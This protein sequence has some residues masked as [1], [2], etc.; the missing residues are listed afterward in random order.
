MQVGQKLKTLLADVELEVQRIVRPG[1]TDQ[2]LNLVPMVE[3]GGDQG[4]PVL[5]VAAGVVT[6]VGGPETGIVVTGPD[7]THYNYVH[8]EAPNVHEQQTVT[9]GRTLGQIALDPGQRAH[10]A[11]AVFGPDGWVD[12][13]PH[14]VGP[15]GVQ[16]APE[17]GPAAEEPASAPDAPPA[18]PEPPTPA[19]DMR[20]SLEDEAAQLRAAGWTVQPPQDRGPT[21]PSGQ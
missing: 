19:P 12:P 5:A 7:G 21:A 6:H 14:L 18:A 4:T 17:P 10:V 8:V 16:E 13:T 2:Q 15:E 20:P 11:F 3:L 9:A 1:E